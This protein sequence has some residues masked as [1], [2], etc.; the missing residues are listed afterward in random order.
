MPPPFSFTDEELTLLN[1]L[2]SPLP[3]QERSGFLSLV[4]TMVEAHP[5][6]ARGPGLVHRL[7]VGAQRRF[8][9]GR[10]LVAVGGG[11][12]SGRSQR[13]GRYG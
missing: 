10:G 4:A 7:A 13:R 12:K 3:P 6:G 11:G 1:A 2:A 9:Q 5:P 8:L